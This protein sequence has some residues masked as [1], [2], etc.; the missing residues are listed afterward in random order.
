MYVVGVIV[1]VVVDFKPL[2]QGNHLSSVSDLPK[3]NL[4]GSFSMF[5]KGNHTGTMHSPQSSGVEE[6]ALERREC[7]KDDDNNLVS[8]TDESEEEN[9]EPVNEEYDEQIS[10]YPRDNF[11]SSP[12]QMMDDASDN[13]DG[14]AEGDEGEEDGEDYEVEDPGGGGDDDDDV[15]MGGEDDI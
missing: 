13:N 12:V 3:A 2:D 1:A 15:D 6:W 8:Q 9:G 10:V 14:N 5:S 4:L 7:V 11:E